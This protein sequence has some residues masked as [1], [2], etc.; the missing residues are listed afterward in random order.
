MNSV[1]IRGLSVSEK[2]WHSLEYHG[3]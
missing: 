2:Y 3:S 1:G